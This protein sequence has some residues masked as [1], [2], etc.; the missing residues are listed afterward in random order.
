MAVPADHTLPCV[1]TYRRGHHGED[2]SPGA[3]PAPRPR[4][5]RMAEEGRGKEPPRTSWWSAADQIQFQAWL[6]MYAEAP[7]AD[8]R[9]QAQ[10]QLAQIMLTGDRLFLL[11]CRIRDY[12]DPVPPTPAR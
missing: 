4:R 7:D 2:R 5:A 9:A 10:A 11:T 3:H 12:Y 6:R 1:H 8:I